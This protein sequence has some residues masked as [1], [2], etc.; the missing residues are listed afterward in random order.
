KANEQHFK[1]A[2]NGKVIVNEYLQVDRSLWVIGDNAATQWSGLAQTALRD[3]KFVANN[4]RRKQDHRKLKRYRAATPQ[5]VVPV[6]RGWAIYS[7]KKIV[8]TGW[9]G[10]IPRRVADMIGYSDILPLRHA[11]RLW[12]SEAEYED[13]YFGPAK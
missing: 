10:H 2:P 5:V 12:G 1:F 7:W 3:A 9:L 11:I 13:D 8:M 4:I 6:G